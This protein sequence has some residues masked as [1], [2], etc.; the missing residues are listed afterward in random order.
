MKIKIVG[1]LITSILLYSCSDNFLDKTKLGALTTENYFVTEADAFQSV[2]AAYSDLKDYR[3]TGTIWCF[4]DVLSEDATYS[5]S[6]DDVQAYALMESYNY[7]AD[8]GRILDRWRILFRGVNKANQAIDGISKMDAGLFKTHNKNR[9]LAEALFLRAYFY[10]E[11]VIAF[12]DVP[13]MTKTPTINDKTLTRTPVDQVYAQIEKDLTDAAGYLPSKSTLNMTTE[14]G[15]ITKA[16]ANA[17]LSRVYLYEKK[18][19][20]CKTASKAVFAETDYKLV[21]NYADVFKLSGEHCS[22]SILEVTQYDSPSGS[23]VTYLNNNGDFHVLL[24]MPSGTTYG[25]GYNQPTKALAKAYISEGDSIRKHA[26]LLTTD[27]LRVWESA[28]NFA[29]LVRNRTGFYNQKFYLKPNE[30][31]LIRSN[32]GTNIRL[33]R[34]PEVYLNYAEACA[35]YPTAG[36]GEVEARTYLNNVRTRVHLAE[37]NSTGEALFNDIMMER[38]LEFGGEGRRYWDMVRTGKAASA[39]ISKGV[40]KPS[41]CNLMPVPQAEIDA[42]GGTITQNPR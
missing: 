8:N 7:P 29:K 26:T 16:A 28:A 21:A 41:S 33:I 36:D 2:V 42:S 15:R 20:A 37:K 17:M 40:F 5:G 12:G 18:Y 25:Y 35:L 22:E 23:N 10:H 1:I 19:D 34:L 38:R 32:N 14:A 30:R 6:D 27:S 3:Y 4:G 13:L 9:L 31:S 11:L 39:F 24:M